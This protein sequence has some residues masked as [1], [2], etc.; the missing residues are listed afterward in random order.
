MCKC[1]S[2]GVF[3]CVQVRGC[4]RV[5]ARVRECYFASFWVLLGRLRFAPWGLPWFVGLV[6][7]SL[8]L[9]VA[10]LLVVGLL[11][12]LVSQSLKVL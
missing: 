10:I 6:C 3:V 4:V 8:A 2:V 1:V 5:R 9:L 12:Y 11:G 7:G